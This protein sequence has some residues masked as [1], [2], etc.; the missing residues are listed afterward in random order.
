M[1]LGDALQGSSRD[2]AGW[3]A[4]QPRTAGPGKALISGGETTVLVRGSGYGGR[5]AEFIHALALAWTA[6]TGS[7]LW[8]QIQT[9]L[10]AGLCRT[11]LWPGL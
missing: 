7:A 1:I 3:M 2:L 5:N 4:A 9:V 11:G 6:M 8:P 10:T